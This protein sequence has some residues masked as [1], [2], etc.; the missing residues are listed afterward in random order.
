MENLEDFVK[1]YRE[2]VQRSGGIERR[3]YESDGFSFIGLSPLTTVTCPAGGWD[4]DQNTPLYTYTCPY[5]A[6][7]H[8]HKFLA[9]VPGATSSSN[10]CDIKLSDMAKNFLNNTYTLITVATANRSE[11]TVPG[12]SLRSYKWNIVDIAYKGSTTGFMSGMAWIYLQ[13]QSAKGRY[14]IPIRL[15]LDDTSKSHYSKTYLLAFVDDMTGEVY[16]MTNHTGSFNKSAITFSTPP[17]KEGYVFKGWRGG[18]SILNQTSS[19]I[20]YNAD[21]VISAIWGRDVKTYTVRFEDYD[22]ST[23]SEKTYEEGETITVPRNPS[24]PGY[25]FT[26]WNPTVETTA[27]K[28]I[29]YRATYSTQSYDYTV[30]FED[31]DGTLISE[32]SY[33]SGDTIVKPS[34]PT[35]GGYIFNGWEPN[36]PSTCTKS[37]T[38]VATYIKDEPTPTGPWLVRFI[39][40]DGSVI[41]SKEYENGATITVPS[42][43]YREFHEFLDWSP[44]VKLTATE[45]ITYTATYREVSTYYTIVFKSWDGSVISSTS[46][47]R[48]SVIAVPTPPK[49]Q[50]YRFTGWNPEI[51]Q[52]ATEDVTYV[53]TYQFAEYTATFIDWDGTVIKTFTYT[54]GSVLAMPP[55][56]ERP[57]YTFIKWNLISTD[58]NGNMTYQAEYELTKYTIIFRNWNGDLISE[59]K[60]DHGSPITIPEAPLRTGYT[61]KE[62]YPTVQLTALGDAEYFPAYERI[63]TTVWAFRVDGSLK[64]KYEKTDLEKWFDK[65]YNEYEDINPEPATKPGYFFNY[66]EYTETVDDE[67]TKTRTYYFDANFTQTGT[68]YRF[69]AE[70]KYTI[71]QTLEYPGIG[72]SDY[73]QYVYPSIPTKNGYKFNQWVLFDSG[74]GYFSY[75]A[76]WN[77]WKFAMYKRPNMPRNKYKIWLQ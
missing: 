74:D 63:Y 53:A 49:R 37:A 43:P 56:P 66:W 65:D 23:I 14:S 73:D 8:H 9:Y 7:A 58:D 70:N 50:N 61:F 24:R 71:I 11:E 67:E 15:G 22:G 39:D 75:Y 36:P 2:K 51:S 3:G 60:Y 44:T 1:E 54:E 38:Y 57:G 29:T 25:T 41:S 48:G 5:D 30:R 35:R 42:N 62:W 72:T 26:G 16:R 40:W 55:N 52:T 45:D 59:T 46:Y 33:N 21:C 10:K 69:Y 20:S 68:I 27:T 64:Q 19:T 32:K 4:V 17:T 47:L 13:N 31:W 12:G 28:D 18:E 77:T 76:T 6:T 34:N